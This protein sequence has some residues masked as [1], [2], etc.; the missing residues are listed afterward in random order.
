MRAYVEH[1][2]PVWPIPR[3]TRQVTTDARGWEHCYDI[4]E[5][6]EL[7]DYASRE[8][9]YLLAHRRKDLREL[10]GPPYRDGYLYGTRGMT[11][12]SFQQGVACIRRALAAMSM[13]AGPVLP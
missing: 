5:F 12:E 8:R 2:H 13:C 7:S 1:G 3:R 9:R 11:D 10:I 6:L 4:V